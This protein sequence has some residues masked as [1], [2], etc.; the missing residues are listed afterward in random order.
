MDKWILA[1]LK[2]HRSLIAFSSALLLFIINAALSWPSFD[3]TRAGF[4]FYPG[5]IVYSLFLTADL[6]INILLWYG[7]S[8]NRKSFIF[9]PLIL[10]GAYAWI[11]I[12][13]I[14][15]GYVFEI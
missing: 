9:A 11:F 1:L 12:V 3:I 2:K 7:I 15:G 10:D 5:V 14:L 8:R 13:V 6:V 4:G